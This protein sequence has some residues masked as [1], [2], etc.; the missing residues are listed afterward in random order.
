MN[1]NSSYAEEKLTFS[2]RQNL[3]IMHYLE[4]ISN[5]RTVSFINLITVNSSYKQLL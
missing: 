4:N 2:C 5:L 3:L 1:V